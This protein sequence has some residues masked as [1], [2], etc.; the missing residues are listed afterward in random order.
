MNVIG[1]GIQLVFTQTKNIDVNL[2]N[3][4]IQTLDY[5]FKTTSLTIYIKAIH[6]YFLSNT[7]Q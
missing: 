6:T 4:I 3:I 2:M 1:I 5:I 7:I